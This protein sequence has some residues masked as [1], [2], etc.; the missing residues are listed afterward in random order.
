MWGGPSY[1][2]FFSRADESSTNKSNDKTRTGQFKVLPRTKQKTVD[3]A[4]GDRCG[5]AAICCARQH[6]AARPHWHKPL[7]GT[8]KKTVDFATGIGVGK[9]YTSFLCITT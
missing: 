4:T 9:L 8:K 6:M 1:I 7:Q 5:Q 2:I 3:F